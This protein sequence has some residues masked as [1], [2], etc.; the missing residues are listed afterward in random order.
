MSEKNL[1][2]IHKLSSAFLYGGKAVPV[3]FDVSFNIKYGEVLGVVGESGSGKS[4]TAKSVM[5]LLPPRSSTIL[6][7]EITLDGEKI[8]EKTEKQM[9]SIRGNKVSMIFQEPMTSLNPVFTCGNQIL[10]AITMHQHVTNEEART[11]A[12]EMLDMVGITMPA[13]RLKAYPHELSGGMRQRV[14]IAMALCC[15]PKLLIADEPTTALDPTIQAQIMLLLKQMRDKLGMGIMYITHDLSVVAQMCDR[16][17]VMYAGMIQEIAEVH[18]LFHTPMHPYTLG[19]MQAMPTMGSNSR[20]L[21]TIPGRVPH[22]TQ[23]PTGC[24]FSPRCPY[25][26]E[27]CNEACPTLE[28]V[29]EEHYVRCFNYSKMER[30]C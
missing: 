6:N 8:L 13:A 5:R 20:R 15:N 3:I 1:L 19:L 11:R 25:A 24:H 29:G 27:Q 9:Q 4:V 22:I 17:V 2:E 30:K 12:I 16:V 14:M 26:T 10:E 23:M 7:G 28:K 21:Y 18:T